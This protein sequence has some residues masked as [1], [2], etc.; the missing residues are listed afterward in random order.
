M[1]RRSTFFWDIPA[2]ETLLLHMDYRVSFLFGLVV[3]SAELAVAVL[4]VL[5]LLSL[6][7]KHAHFDLEL[8][9]SM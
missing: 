3:A 6:H 5:V 7:A 1:G 8:G 2:L 9:V 4:T